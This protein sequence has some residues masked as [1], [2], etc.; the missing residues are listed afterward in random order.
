L[1]LNKI[2]AVLLVILFV[3]FSLAIIMTW[4]AGDAVLDADAYVDTLS[5]AGFFRVPYQLIRDGQIPGVGG[6]LLR[7]GPLSVLSG[8]DLE[9]VARE[10]APPA[11]LRA[12]LERALRDLVAVTSEPQV[13]ELPSVVF[14]LSEVKERALGEPGDQALTIV[15]ENLPVCA[16]GEPSLDLNR[17]VPLCKPPDFDLNPFL[18]QLRGL[19]T[20]LV[21]R[22]PDTYQVTWRPEQR[23][24][25][26]DLQR[27]GQTL[28]KL[29]FVMLLL[30]ALNLA[31]L[32]LIWVLVVRSPA[33]WLRWTGV[34]LLLLGLVTL[35]LA[36]LVPR[37]VTLGLDSSALW[38]GGVLP[39]PLAESLEMA[40]RDFV[41]LLFRP[42]RMVGLILL[43][44]GALLTLVS[45]L[46]PGPRWQDA[47]SPVGAGRSGN[48]SRLR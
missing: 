6:L 26:E 38:V 18:N 9:A 39:G 7:E 3:F 22:V 14:N 8:D 37:V 12:Q 13:N 25:L 42:A 15:A 28:E 11:W 32:G 35:L 40:I 34:P 23:G 44:V 43:V 33:E 27:A 48:F 19:L 47:D 30:V 45:P 31:L 29:Q 1:E 5:D 2:I 24:V 10:L 46:F 20:P 16:P 41:F 4:S 17:D 21:N 36:L